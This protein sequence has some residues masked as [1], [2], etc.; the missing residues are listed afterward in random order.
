MVLKQ[1]KKNKRTDTCKGTHIQNNVLVLL[2]FLRKDNNYAI[3][4]VK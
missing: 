4:E 2:L 3:D 1:P